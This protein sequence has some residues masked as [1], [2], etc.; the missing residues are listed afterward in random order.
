MIRLL[1]F[2][3]F[4]SWAIVFPLG[5]PVHL[6]LD[7]RPFARAHILAAVA[8]VENCAALKNPGCIL[9]A[10]QCGADRG[11]H[12]YARFKNIAMGQRALV[13][14]WDQH[15]CIALDEA[16]R[17]YNPAN[18]QYARVVLKLAGVPKDTVIGDCP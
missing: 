2:L 10:H 15:G 18:P 11:P 9:Y 13:N 3:L 7:I 16:L 14:W 5:A 1:R 4:P 6:G 12:G 17:V 8:R